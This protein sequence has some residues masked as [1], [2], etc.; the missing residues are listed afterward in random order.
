M[1]T[2]STPVPL[3]PS[4]DGWYLL[5]SY[6]T[7]PHPLGLQR[8]TLAAA[9]NIVRHHNSLYGRLKRYFGGIPVYIGHPDDPAFSHLPTHSDSRAYAWIHQLQ[10][11][12]DGLYISPIWSARGKELLDNAHYKHLSVRWRLRA[13]PD[14]TFEP[15]ELL[16]VGLTN[17]PNIPGPTI[18]NAQLPTPEEYL[19]PIALA[20]GLPEKSTPEA[21][22]QKIGQ[23]N[24]ATAAAS[25]RLALINAQLD[26]ALER[27]QIT[28]AQKPL[29]QEKLAQAPTAANELSTL[30]RCGAAA[31]T[32]ISNEDRDFR[33]TAAYLR[34]EFV[35]TVENRM[36]ETGEDFSTAWASLKQK[37]ADIYHKINS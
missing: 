9:Q 32:F 26:L 33:A 28:P 10:A 20:L 7:H 5:S 11:R 14:K 19:T 13:L 37:R 18:A 2:P 34:A 23:M 21:I 4:A 30:P 35:R 29:W 27:G 25:D 22:A 1:N 24:A 36:K 6:G 16:S 3:S 12:P 31:T 15:I 17:Q 8:F